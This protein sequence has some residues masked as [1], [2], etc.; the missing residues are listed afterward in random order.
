MNRG[1]STVAFAN[2]DYMYI[3]EAAVRNK[4]DGVEIRLD[5]QNNLF[6]HPA[7]DTEMIG[8]AFRDAGIEISDIG[9]SVCIKEYIPSQ[10]ET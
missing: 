5:S 10:V 3:I 4:M 2:L 6:G 1:F 8:N 9:T 7:E